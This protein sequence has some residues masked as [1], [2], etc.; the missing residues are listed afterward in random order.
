VDEEEGC[1]LTTMMV[2]NATVLLEATG[3]KVREFLE[4]VRY[5]EP[6]PDMIIVHCE[7]PYVKLLGPL[8]Q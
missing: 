3:E 4:L 1:I 8:G 7:A 5:T 6:K 2:V